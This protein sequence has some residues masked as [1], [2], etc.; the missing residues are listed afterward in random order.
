MGNFGTYKFAFF[1]E[2]NL[3]GISQY[4][5]FTDFDNKDFTLKN[6]SVLK[7]AGQPVLAGSDGS[8]I[9]FDGIA[10]IGPYMQLPKPTNSSIFKQGG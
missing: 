9:S 7:Y 6:N 2:N 1:G 8:N 10:N 4:E 3:T 5:N